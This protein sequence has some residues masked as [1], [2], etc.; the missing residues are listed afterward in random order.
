MQRVRR[1][2]LVEIPEEWEGVVTFRQTIR[3]RPSKWTRK[4]RKRFGRPFPQKG[5]PR[6]HCPRHSC[7]GRLREEW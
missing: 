6:N 3:K 7:G 1:G 2:R 4:A 5:H